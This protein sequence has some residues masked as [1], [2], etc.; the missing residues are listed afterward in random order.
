MN[1]SA[2]IVNPRLLRVKRELQDGKSVYVSSH[3]RYEIRC[4]KNVLSGD[5]A[6]AFMNN[7][8]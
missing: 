4:T 7:P 3:A 1:I 2:A 5:F 6:Q 8:G